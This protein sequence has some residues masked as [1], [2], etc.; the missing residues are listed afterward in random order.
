MHVSHG[1]ALSFCT[2]RRE[3]KQALVL[4]K[5]GI[6]IVINQSR[7]CVVLEVGYAEGSLLHF[8]RL[9]LVGGGDPTTLEARAGIELVLIS[10][11]LL[12]GRGTGR[13]VDRAILARQASDWNGVLHEYF[14]PC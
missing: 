8:R 9:D 14:S 7:H 12:L 11:A 1:T 4:V 10:Q 6:Q 2:N 13:M 5:R 3:S